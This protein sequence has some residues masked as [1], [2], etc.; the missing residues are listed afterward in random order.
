MALLFERTGPSVGPIDLDISEQE[1]H[2]VSVDLT[3]NPLEDGTE[4]ADHFIDRPDV[5]TLNVWVSDAIL[6]ASIPNRSVDAWRRLRAAVKRHE[7][8]DI[9]TRSQRYQRYALISLNLNESRAS[10]G[11]RNFQLV[12]REVHFSEVDDIDALS[13]LIADQGAGEADLGTQGVA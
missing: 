9:V 3:E 7:V 13:D 2:A 10:R 12:C 8:Y 11:G 4:V 6:T 5:V 1:T